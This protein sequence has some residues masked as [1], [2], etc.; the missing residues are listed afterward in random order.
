MLLY[1][2]FV[3]PTCY[4]IND[5]VILVE[6]FPVM[7][8]VSSGTLLGCVLPI[9]LFFITVILMLVQKSFSFVIDIP[10]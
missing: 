4:N 5:V 3:I 7:R 8:P 2:S 6:F 1:G 9:C 10:L